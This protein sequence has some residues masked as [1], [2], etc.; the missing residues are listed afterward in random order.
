[1]IGV[2]G[3]NFYFIIEAH[4]HSTVQHHVFTTDRDQDATAAHILASTFKEA[5]ILL[6]WQMSVLFRIMSRILIYGEVKEENSN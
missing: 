2:R 4:V 6:D 1:L 3:S 5:N